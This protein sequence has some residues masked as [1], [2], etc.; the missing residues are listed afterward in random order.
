MD[1]FSSLTN[2][3]LLCFHYCY[4]PLFHKL[5]LTWL[6][7]HSKSP[8]HFLSQG[9]TCKI[10]GLAYFTTQNN[11]ILF[12]INFK[13]N[14]SSNYIF[15]TDLLQIVPAPARSQFTKIDN[16]CKKPLSYAISL[17]SPNVKT[18]WLFFQ[19]DLWFS[20]FSALSVSVAAHIC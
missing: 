11:L 15:K 14:S 6:A 12:S 20:D 5:N 16:S 10:C 7:T 3:Q 17:A 2:T 8:S 13:C 19:E 1:T 4:T 18:K 9:C